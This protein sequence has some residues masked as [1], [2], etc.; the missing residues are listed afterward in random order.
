M[1]WFRDGSA[2][3][4]LPWLAVMAAVWL[5]G[6][7]LVAHAFRLG[8]RE[9]L[10][11]GFG[12]GV[13]LYAWLANILGQFLAP[14]LAFLAPAAILLALGGWLAWRDKDVPWLDREDLGVWPWLL[15]GLFAIWVFLLMGKG[16]AIFDEH[17][18]LSLI[19][20]IANGDLPP[21]FFLDYP[22][23][24]VYHYG[25]H[26][27]GASLMRLGGL[28]PWSAFDLAKAILFGASLLL[29]G[30]LGQRYV[31]GAR[32]ALLAA[33]VLAF[34][35][36][37]RYLLFFLPP[38]ILLRADQLITLQGTSAFIGKPFS[39]ALSSGWTIDGGPPMDYIF[40]FLNG[41]MDPL[42]MAHQGPNIL[43]VMIFLLVWLL[44]TQ[45]R[46][47]WSWLLLAPVFAMWA[48][49]WEATYALFM[50]GLFLFAGL[51]FWRWRTLEL[52]HLKPALYAALLSVPIVALQ[53]GTITETLRDALFGIEGRF[54]VGS[55]AVSQV[56]AGVPLALNWVSEA[57][58]SLLGFSL[59][60]P[61][62]ILSAHLGALSL[63]S[64]VELLVGLFEIGPVL[65]FTP[66]ITRWA[67]RRSRAGDWPLGALLVAA[68]VGFLMPVF[69]QYKADRDISRLSWQALLIWTL[70]LALMVGDKAFRWRPWLR[71]TALLGLGLM[72]FGGLVI[73]GIQLTAA[74]TTQL[75]H[76]YTELDST[77]T[78]AVWG[79]FERDDK[80]F[81]PLGNTTV[82]TGQLTGQLLGEPRA[83][84]YWAALEADPRLDELLA[85]DFDYLFV[86]SREW[87]DW[88]PEFQ[89]ELEA[90]CVTVVA[91]VWDN[92]QINFR[93]L[94]DLRACYPLVQ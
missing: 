41:I 25:F 57:A 39:E 72:L 80:I 21:R 78:S 90:E 38:G 27:F 37:T 11:A 52:P 14:G 22:L 88:Q 64:P 74:S 55:A 32:G 94:L 30:L 65:L 49:A 84:H 53:G 69:L 73:F 4:L 9:R 58:S 92:A 51:A 43:S 91:E 6:W 86:D 40:G 48:L 83:D 89:A 46:G 76:T 34:A 20:V 70:M 2:L 31:G 63:F 56:G 61:P 75:A 24:Y 62:A 13:V 29:A 8:R 44:L 17:K 3:S 26:V 67:W 33:G 50:V 16:L 42:V 23:N 19:S 87:R 66:W 71:K 1:Y 79:T 12:L 7:L 18:N 81:G 10:I 47:R 60:W 28:L 82:I 36:G 59:R 35:T 54:L 93:R 15:A 5:G 85:R 77:M 68:W 45:L